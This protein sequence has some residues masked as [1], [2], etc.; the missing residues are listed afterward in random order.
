MKIV[1]IIRSLAQ[2]AGVER[3]MS[4][5]MNYLAEHGFEITVITYDQGKHPYAY[6]LHQTIRHIDLNMCFFK[7]SKYNLII[8]LAHLIRLRH[9]FRRHL[10]SVLDSIKPDTIVVSTCSIKLMDI[11]LSVRSNARIIVE[12]HAP[13]YA[14]RKSFYYKNKPLLRFLASIYDN[15]MLRNIVKA[16]LLVVLTEG[17]ANEWRKYISNVK[18]IPN[19]I[20]SFPE[21]IRSHDDCRSRI[22]CA[23]RL[24]KEKRFNMVIEAF[25]MIA[26]KC[27]KWRVD[28]YGEGSEKDELLRLI[29]Q[30]QLSDRVFVNNPTVDI[31]KEYQES[32]FFVL[33]SEYEGFGLVLIEAMA[34][35]I[36]CVSFKCK[37]GPEDIINDGK[38]GLLVD[39]GN[40]IDLSEKMLWMISHREERL[41]MGKNAREA[42]RRYKKQ[43]VMQQW[44]NLFENK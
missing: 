28:I 15:K 18:I 44:I 7:L 13:C 21:K 8:R 20:T 39:D 5:K 19:P 3:V 33:S 31:F 36:P 2:K 22:L 6:P 43:V 12:S 27:P 30:F 1:Y 26:D 16:N 4:D 10:Q 29:Q 14:I 40:I 11:I 35:G 32:D 24:N 25:A 42:V 37:Y 23:G 17:D 38:D 34:C 41:C 9:Q